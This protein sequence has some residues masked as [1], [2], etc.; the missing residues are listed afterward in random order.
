MH[1][2][3]AKQKQPKLTFYLVILT[4]TAQ[5]FTH[6]LLVTTTQVTKQSPNL[7]LKLYT[8]NSIVS[9]LNLI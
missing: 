9:I 4:P 8:S 7:A 2:V 5:L 1:E 6:T 3:K